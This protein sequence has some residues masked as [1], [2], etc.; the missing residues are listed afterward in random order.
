MVLLNGHPCS[1]T[2]LRRRKRGREG[3]TD[4]KRDRV[5][6]C[7]C[8]VLVGSVGLGRVPHELTVP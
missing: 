6:V 8:V 4:A 5:C 2:I 3:Y 7:V 1:G